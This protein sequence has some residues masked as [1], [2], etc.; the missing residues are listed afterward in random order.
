MNKPSF[1]I[2]L[3]ILS[4]LSVLHGQSVVY[5]EGSG[6]QGTLEKQILYNGRVWRNL[7][8]RVD[9][10]PFLI[11]SQFLPGTV[12][13]G[14]KTF[15]NIMIRYD[16]YKDQIQI[17]TDKVIILQ[18]NKELVDG[19][20]IQFAEMTYNFRKF[21]EDDLSPVSGYVNIAYNGASS[22]FVKYKKEIDV[23]GSDNLFGTFYQL[24][25]AHGPF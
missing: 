6:E 15:D 13:I 18:L 5:S 4:G 1:L 8:S 24:Q 2:F 9:G 17:L 11:V 3:L 23:S 21:E 12:T 22:L 16:I 20:T 10:Y 7:Y 25:R 14:G 19:F